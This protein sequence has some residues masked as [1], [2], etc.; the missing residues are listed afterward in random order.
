[1][2]V[3]SKQ[4]LQPPKIIRFP[5]FMIDHD[6]SC[7]LRRYSWALVEPLVHWARNALNHHRL[8]SQVECI[9]T[10]LHLR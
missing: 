2:T 3:H 4:Y 1:M 10:L 8:F 9:R 6:N 7:G 5:L